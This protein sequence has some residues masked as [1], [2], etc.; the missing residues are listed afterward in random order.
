MQSLQFRRYKYP[1]WVRNTCCLVPLAGFLVLCIGV[2]FGLDISWPV[3]FATA[4][5]SGYVL[6]MVI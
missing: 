1:A 4:G 6:R 2:V 3:T 5:L